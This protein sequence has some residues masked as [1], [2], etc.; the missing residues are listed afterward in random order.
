MPGQR[1]ADLRAPPRADLGDDEYIIEEVEEEFDLDARDPVSAASVQDF[2]NTLCDD[3]DVEE[4]E[5]ESDGFHLYVRREARAAA[6]PALAPSAA[7]AAFP[8]A[9]P[10]ASSNAGDTLDIADL[11]GDEEEADESVVPV[12]STMVG[13][14]RRKN[15]A[16]GK[17]VGKG[18]AVE[19]G[20]MVKAG[21]ILCMIEQLGTLHPIKAPQA[22]E[23][24][25]F[26]VKDG[27]P[28]MYGQ[29]ILELSPFFGGH[30]IGDSK[31]A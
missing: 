1:G 17:P 8:A 7:P 15:Y 5:I 9:A 14:L 3:T 23:V 16:R 24:A 25:R 30:I 31:H 4:V 20:D 11:L 10:K 18:N 29:T 12:T 21:G 28:V 2:L 6:A 27:E 26:V 13:T 22:G 19:E